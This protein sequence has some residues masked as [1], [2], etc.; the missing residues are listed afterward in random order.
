MMNGRF[1]DGRQIKAY[2]WDGKTDYRIN[3]ETA[4]EQNKRI[5]EFGEWLEQQRLKEEEEEE[6]ANKQTTEEVD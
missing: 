4:E 3:R 1:F 5:D 2:Y 6:Q